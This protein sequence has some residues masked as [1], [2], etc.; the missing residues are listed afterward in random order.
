VHHVKHDEMVEGARAVTY[1]EQALRQEATVLREALTLDVDAATDVLRRVERVHL[2]GTGSSQHAAEL[3]AWMLRRSG[4][5]ASWWSSS[6]AAGTAD[7]RDHAVI[8]ISHTGETAFAR[9]VRDQVLSAGTAQLIT[10]TGPTADW[11]EALRVAPREKAETYTFSYTAALL[12]LAKIAGRL[13]APAFTDE[14]LARAVDAAAEAAA[15]RPPDVSGL[16]P[17]VLAGAGPA[18]VTAREGALKLREAAR[19]HAVGYE[20]EY[21]LHGSAV[22]L[23]AGD[24]LILLQPAADEGLVSAIGA[25]AAAE[26][27]TVHEVSIDADLDPVLVQLPLT[28]R[29]QTMASR[30]AYDRAQDPDVVITGAW[31]DDRLW[32][33]GCPVQ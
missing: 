28:V 31:R 11:P 25:A 5:D 6:T 19:L 18:A 3:G 22:P 27:V 9:T 20:A 1:L 33:F 29:L 14:A 8:V 16:G 32:S 26:A 12:V 13:G 15:A 17:I 7:W 21:L 23:G 30:L 2:V 24:E 4:L 10:L